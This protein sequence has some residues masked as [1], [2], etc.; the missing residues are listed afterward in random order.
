MTHK[1]IALYAGASGVSLLLLLGAF[2]LVEWSVPEQVLSAHDLLVLQD[3]E[4]GM[5]R[6]HAGPTIA[7]VQSE[8][9]KPED[10]DSR[11]L[12]QARQ[13]DRRL[14]AKGASSPGVNPLVRALKKRSQLLDRAVTV[15]VDTTPP[16]STTISLKDFPEWLELKVSLWSAEYAID[17]AAVTAALKEGKI[18]GLPLVQDASVLSTAEDNKKVLRATTTAATRPGLDIDAETSAHTIA[19]ALMDDDTPAVT[20]HGTQRDATVAIKTDDGKEQVLTLLG[21]GMSDFAGSDPGRLSNLMKAFHERVHNV[22][23][24]PGGVFSLVDSLNP[25]VTLE[26][27]WKEALGLFG[28]GAALTPGGGIC[29]SATTTY[30]AALLSGLPIV[31]KRNHSLFVDHYEFYGIG[32]DATIFP[33]IHDM[34]FRNDTSSDIILQ[35]RT[36]GDTAYVYIYG[37]DDGR[38]VEMDG[39]YFYGAKNRPAQLKPLSYHQIGWV[40]TVKNADGSIREQAPIVATNSKPL[41]GSLIKQ[42]QSSNGMALLTGTLL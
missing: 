9:D 14:K 24:K 10:A 5:V 42:Y 17:E 2:A 23:V 12:R 15:T 25:P 36:E 1:H 28:G 21:T 32:L 29:Q 3:G 38:T 8:T 18:T 31:Q 34:R 40:R 13:M 4:E 20:L 37:V 41:W 6:T 30:R 22:V 11:T 27:G 16:V 35:A 26:K 19:K 39:P 33:G 7:S